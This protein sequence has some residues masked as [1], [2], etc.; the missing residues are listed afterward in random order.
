MTPPKAPPTAGARRVAIADAAVSLLAAGGMHALSHRAIDQHLKLPAGSTS[1]YYR[2]R[3]AL[4]EAVVERVVALDDADLSQVLA[5][6]KPDS[7]LVFDLFSIWSAPQQRE[8]LAARFELLLAGIRG[9][10]PDTMLMAR[11]HFVARTREAVEQ[12]GVADAAA[13]TTAIVA[14]FDGLLLDVLASTA[15][16]AAGTGAGTDAGTDPGQPARHH[17][18]RNLEHLL[19]GNG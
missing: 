14:L 13:I 10:G 11:R 15:G 1:Y 17:L 3:D 4:V 12:A 19:E 8:R 9:D 16:T 2:S 6:K 7:A 5:A 18:L